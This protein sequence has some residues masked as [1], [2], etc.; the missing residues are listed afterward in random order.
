MNNF[1]GYSFA[2]ANAKKGLFD[3]DLNINQ[4]CPSEYVSILESSGGSHPR[5]RNSFE[6]STPKGIPNVYL[7]I[8]EEKMILISYVPFEFRI[9]V[10]LPIKIKLYSSTPPFLFEIG[11]KLRVAFSRN[12]NEVYEEYMYKD[13][14]HWPITFLLFR[15]Q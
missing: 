2:A 1:G 4:L 12:F 13:F 6:Y 7:A 8:L 5:F 10:N 9:R 3:Y 15:I 11:L 14:N